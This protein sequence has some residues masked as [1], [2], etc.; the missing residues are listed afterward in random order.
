M[1]KSD[2]VSDSLDKIE[3]H[4]MIDKVNQFT[5]TYINSRYNLHIL[6]T[7][8]SVTESSKYHNPYR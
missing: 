3:P 5:I 1:N 6:I 4:D 8:S 2:L 7:S